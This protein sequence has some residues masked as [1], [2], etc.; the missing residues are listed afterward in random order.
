MPTREFS[1]RRFVQLVGAV[2]TVAPWFGLANKAQAQP[3][4]AFASIRR[5][6][7]KPGSAAE[8]ARR[9]PDVVVPVLRSLP[10]FVSFQMIYGDNDMVTAITVYTSESAARDANAKIIPIVRE[11]FGPLLAGPLEPSAGPIIASA[12]A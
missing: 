11:V 8:L 5:A 7:V 6:P 9:V 1:K 12:M 2:A 10:G 3:S 4:A